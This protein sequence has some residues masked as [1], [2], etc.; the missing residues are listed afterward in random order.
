MKATCGSQRRPSSRNLGCRGELLPAPL[1]DAPESA[2]SLTARSHIRG[3]S[4]KLKGPIALKDIKRAET[5]DVPE[6]KGFGLKVR[7]LR[8][9]ARFIVC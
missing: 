9:R 8:R 2:A 5:C 6:D 4:G 7:H 1:L 3:N